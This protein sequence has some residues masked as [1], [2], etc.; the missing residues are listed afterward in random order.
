[1]KLLKPVD[2]GFVSFVDR[3][4]RMAAVQREHELNHRIAPDVYLGSA[5][6]WRTA[7]WSSGC[8]S[9]RRLP[10][11]RQLDRLVG[12]PGFSDHIVE[13]A[14]FLAVFHSRQEPVTGDDASMAT[15]EQLLANWR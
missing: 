14:R 12:T 1:M 13:V 15:A 10:A 7:R 2:V 6:W 3:A 5:T 4:T 9:M 8:S 11:D